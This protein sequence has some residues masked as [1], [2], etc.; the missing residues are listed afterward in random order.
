M[1]SGLSVAV[2]TQRYSSYSSEPCGACQAR[3]V[4]AC[5]SLDG[6]E[7]H[8]LTSIMRVVRIARRRVIFE[9]TA[10]ATYVFNVKEG[11]VKTYKLLPDGRRQ[12]TGFLFPG[13]FLGL[14]HNEVYVYSAEALVATELCRFPRRKFETLLEELPKLGQRLLVMASHELSVAQD[15]MMLLGRKTA[16]ERVV[17]FLLMLSY[18]AERRG[19]QNN[20]AVLPMPRGD[21]ADYLGLTI[22]TVSRTL[23]QL[24]LQKLIRLIGDDRVE[25]LQPSA[26]HEITNH[27]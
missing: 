16:R 21:I 7:Q 1:S 14:V 24:K 22:E 25:L 11:A 17:S 27:P 20:P 15:R 3:N 5:R 9:E 12:I 26:L 8:R 18:A 6:D 23:T 19:Q 10:P 4:S 2:D 13:D